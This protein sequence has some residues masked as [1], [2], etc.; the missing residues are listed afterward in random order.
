VIDLIRR[1]RGVDGVMNMIQCP[2]CKQDIDND[3]GF[4]D[5]C[6]KQILV[7][8]KCKRPGK[9]KRC[10]IDGSELVPNN[11]SGS[12]TASDTSDPATINI[13]STQPPPVQPPAPQPP[14]AQA[15]PGAGLSSDK[16]I[17]SG[18]GITIEVSNGDV[19]G[20]SKGPHAAVLGRFSVISGSHC[21]IIKTAA[22]W[23]IEDLG[24]TN[25]T[26]YNNS[27]LAPNS[28]VVIQSNASIKLANVDFTVSF[29]SDDDGA[30]VRV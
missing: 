12:S 8:S 10:I 25:G 17:L 15:S 7:C 14:P 20:R 6:G 18:Q 22:G 9:G 19:L 28:P 3:S 5:Q 26:Y 23:S 21:K 30:T 27:R 29:A 13:D 1:L 24:S 16:I 11:Q 4:C 2:E